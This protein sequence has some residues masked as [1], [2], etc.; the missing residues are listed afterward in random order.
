M[1]KE[2]SPLAQAWAVRAATLRQPLAA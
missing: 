1:A 2:G